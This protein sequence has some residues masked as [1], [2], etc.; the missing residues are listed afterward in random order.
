MGFDP[1]WTYLTDS[2]LLLP[3]W[4]TEIGWNPRQYYKSI[5]TQKRKFSTPKW[6][7]ITNHT[8]YRCMYVWSWIHLVQI[9]CF[10]ISGNEITSIKYSQNKKICRRISHKTKNLI[11]I[12]SSK[13][14][15]IGLIEE[16]IIIGILWK[17]FTMR[18]RTGSNNYVN[19]KSTNHNLLTDL[20]SGLKYIIQD[21]QFGNWMGEQN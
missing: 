4:M 2:W 8:I 7:F 16:K 17:E 20:S 10:A 11:K 9:I 13:F 1:F 5:T 18:S 15:L 14:H 21:S 6:A 19:F 3:E 12:K